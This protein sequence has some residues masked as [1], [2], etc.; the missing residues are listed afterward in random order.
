MLFCYIELH[1]TLSAQMSLF[2]L[3]VYLTQ[4]AHN[5]HG[6]DGQHSNV[7]F[8]STKNAQKTQ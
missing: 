1:Y 6:D 8:A 3:N 5:S 4:N 2:C 7:Y